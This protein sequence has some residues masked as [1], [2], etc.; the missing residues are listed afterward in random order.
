MVF[1]SY[2][3]YCRP[4]LAKIMLAS[5]LLFNAAMSAAQISATQSKTTSVLD[6]MLPAMITA[7]KQE[8]VLALFKPP[9]T[10]AQLV[11]SDY[12]LLDSPPIAAAGIMSVH[13]LSEIPGTEFFLLFN[14]TPAKDE[15]SFLIAQAVPNLTKADVRVKIKLSKSATLTMLVRASGRWYFV[16]NDIKIAT[17]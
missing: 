7:D 6:E 9:V 2:R 5:C 4:P 3:F 15:P 16:N 12:L 11:K 14:S 17:K 8:K 13:M 10:K 1:S